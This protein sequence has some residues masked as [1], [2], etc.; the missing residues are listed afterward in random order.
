[1]NRLPRFTKPVPDGAALALR[2]AVEC[3]YGDLAKAQRAREARA[4][5]LWKIQQ[6]TENGKVALIT[7]SRDCDMCEGTSR[8]IVAAKAHIIDL[9]IEADLEG[10]EGPTNHWL[11]KPSDPFESEFRDRAMEAHEDGHRHIIY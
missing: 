4:H 5:W 2:Q 3:V 1:M 8:R 10:A 6:C 7:W 11:Q 9:S